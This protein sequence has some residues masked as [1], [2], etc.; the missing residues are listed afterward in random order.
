MATPP[1]GSLHDTIEA[2]HRFAGAAPGRRSMSR[3]R[4][5]IILLALVVAAIIWLRTVG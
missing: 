3:V 1:N 5:L 4:P 2:P